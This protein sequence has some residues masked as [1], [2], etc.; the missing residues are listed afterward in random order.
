MNAAVWIGAGVVLARCRRCVRDRQAATG[1][2]EPVPSRPSHSQE[3]RS[4]HWRQTRKSERGA[5][6]FVHGRHR[7]LRGASRRP[8]PNFRQPDVSIVVTV[9]NEAASVD[10]LYRR[11]ITVLDPGPRTFELIF[12]DDGS[13]DGTFAALERLH[14][15]TP[16]CVRSGSSGTSASIPRC[17]PGCR[18]PAATWW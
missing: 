5:L 18:G 10:E 2:Q 8:R 1:R 3:P 15:V 16:A 11:T 6:S 12:I 17:T 14:V 9:F 7:S 13:T 4:S